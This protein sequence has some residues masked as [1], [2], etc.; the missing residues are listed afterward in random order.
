MYLLGATLTK[1]LATAA[2][3]M[4]VTAGLP[5]N[6][7]RCP[8]GQVKLFCHG[9]ASAPSGCCCAADGSASPETKPCCDGAKTTDTRQ[10]TPSKKRSCCAHSHGGSPKEPGCDGPRVVVKAGCCVKTVVA[11]PAVDSVAT[12]SNPAHQATDTLALNEPTFVVPHITADAVA[13]YP[14]PWLLAIPTDLVV[15]L[16]R[17]LC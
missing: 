11:A 6:Q 2:A 16:H 4:T 15:V 17:F 12:A 13:A 3:V 5:S 9:N 14:P 1:L 7:C 8:D 10:P